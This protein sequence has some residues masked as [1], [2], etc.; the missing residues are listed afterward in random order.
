MKISVSRS[1]GRAF[2]IMELF[3]QTQLPASASDISRSLN[4]PHSSIVAVLYT[5]RDMGYLS[6]DSRTM[7]FFPTSKLFTMSS[8]LSPAAT[9]PGRLDRMMERLRRDTGYTVALVS[10]VSLF[11]NTLVTLPGTHP[12]V[13]GPPKAVGAA[14]VNSVPGLVI[15]AQMEEE[16]VRGII[17]DTQLWLRECGARTRIE[18]S[19]TLDRIDAVRRAGCLAGGHPDCSGTEIIAYPLGKDLSGAPLALAAYIPTHLSQARKAELRR[20]LDMRSARSASP[21]APGPVSR[22]ASSGLAITG[23]DVI[24]TAG[25][26]NVRSHSARA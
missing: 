3:Q 16:A 21:I 24:S 6:M 2:A 4:A 11:V 17:R 7:R 1:V 23:P 8:W 22:L 20:R 18:A 15:L 5:L 13:A 14:L 25:L 9:E 10:R 26:A 19:G 12:A